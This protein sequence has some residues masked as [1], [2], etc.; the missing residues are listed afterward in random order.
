[1]TALTAGRNTPELAGQ[2]HSL[3]VGSA[4]KI[5]A[6]ALVCLNATGYAVKGATATTLKSFGRAEE[7]VDN[8]GGG[9]GA[10]SIKVK[11]GIFGFLNSTSTDAITIADIKSDC[12]VVDD[13]TVAKTDGSAS[14]SKAGRVVAVQDG[15]VF[16][17][18]GPQF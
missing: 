9:D 8:S 5:L 3:Q 14:R 2:V 18:L 13:Q 12:Y 7:T 6:G 10:L 11:V 15:L 17:Q 16:V 1:M 4:A